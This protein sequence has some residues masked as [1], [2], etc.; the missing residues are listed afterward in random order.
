MA[1]KIRPS[2]VNN[3]ARYKLIGYSTYNGNSTSPS[4]NNEIGLFNEKLDETWNDTGAFYICNTSQYIEIEIYDNCTIW[5]YPPITYND[6]CAL[7]KIEKMENEKWKDI[8][9]N[10]TQTCTKHLIENWERT[11]VDLPKGH[12]KFSI[13]KD[14]ESRI[15]TE[16][17]IEKSILKYFFIKKDNKIYSLNKNIYK[18]NII[19]RN[20]ED[21]K[22]VKELKNIEQIRYIFK[23]EDLNKYGTPQV[24]ISEELLR[25]LQGFEIIE[26]SDDKEENK[27]N[28]GGEY[29]DKIFKCFEEPEL[30]VWIDDKDVNEV[31][32]IGEI[33]STK[34]LDKAEDYDLL[35]WTDDKNIKEAKITYET[36]PYRPIDALKTINDGTFDVLVKELEN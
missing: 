12:Y 34:I 11:I 21:L 9:E 5:R 17:Y 31:S 30:L 6:Y 13:S 3:E 20:I 29:K 23:K 26:W 10:V 33:E 32:L 24:N 14:G 18:D 1:G 16:W 15:D 28:I 2:N 35:M 8:T 19:P 4:N 36:E 25:K 27:L 7:F 22:I